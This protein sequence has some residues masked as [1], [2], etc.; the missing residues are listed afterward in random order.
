MHLLDSISVKH[1]SK[2]RHV[3]LY[4]GDLAE[5]PREEAV[6]LLVISAFPNDYA[7]TPTSL[8]GA[9]WQR[10]LSV[11]DLARTKAVDLREAFSCWLSEEVSDAS[12][13]FKRVLCFEPLVRGAPA[14]VVGEIFQ[15]L[16]PFAHG[17]PPIATMA[18]PVVASGD[19]GVPPVVMLEPLIDAA[20]HWLAIGLP[21]DRL[22]IV[23]R[24]ER[25]AAELGQRFAELKERHVAP[26]DAGP[27]SFT[28]HVFISYSH[29][30]LGAVEFMVQEL[31]RLR[32]DVRVFLDRQDIRT[33]VAWQ[34]HLFDALDDCHT[35]VAVYSPP[36]L[37]S[38]VCKEEFNIALFRHRE[39]ETGV[40]LPVY[41]RS[42]DL[43]TYMKLVQYIDCREADRDK[44]REACRQIL[45]QLED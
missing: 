10:G 8:I 7:P 14:E 37:R 17:K 32:P 31:K 9:L 38:K 29:Q 44:M 26:G 22:K 36:Y 1:G 28:Y 33:G 2:S 3:E 18:M 5:I 43:P 30:N 24:S 42:A 34:Q 11:A 39:S 40:L 15:S 21:V 13:G 20:V 27:A 6:D 45:A 35:V 41:L 25:K 23:E 16:M 4:L 19:Q 12:L